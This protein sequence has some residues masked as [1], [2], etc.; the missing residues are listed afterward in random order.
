M[1]ALEG[2]VRRSETPA[3]VHSPMNKP[4][5]GPG[6]MVYSGDESV[7]DAV[8]QGAPQ[9]SRVE[10]SHGAWEGRELYGQRRLRLIVLDDE[11]ITDDDI[12]W[13]LGQVRRHAPGAMLIYVADRHSPERERRARTSGAQYYASKPIERDRFI[14]VVRSFARFAA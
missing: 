4:L 12:G 6:I 7:L 3:V 1:S 14:E 10:A 13:L 9:P 8:R 5:G 11:G 2:T